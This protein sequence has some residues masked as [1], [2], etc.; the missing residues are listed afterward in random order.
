[1][2]SATDSMM[3]IGRQTATGRVAR[4][5]LAAAI[6]LVLVGCVSS[7]DLFEA[8]GT[9][10][11]SGSLMN[12]GDTM[13]AAGDH[14]GAV[15]LYRSAHDQQPDQADPLIRMGRAL[16]AAG[17]YAD[18]AEAFRAAL[19]R[20]PASAEAKRGLGNALVGLGQ[21]ALAV[22]YLRDAVQATEASD[23]MPDWRACL[24]LG[25]ALDL[26][27]DPVAA[28]ESYRR[29]L[30]SAPDNPD[31][32]N[33]LGLSLALSGSADQALPMLEALVARHGTQ[34]RY[35]G[36]LAIAYAL[37]GRM[38]D[39]ARLMSRQSPPDMV[40]RNLTSLTAIRAMDDHARKALAIRMV[41]TG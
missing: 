8:R 5:L 6:S 30:E 31:L 15:A 16:A 37:D 25:V 27:G 10:P 13:M 7:N 28:Q 21:P 34:G 2:E 40:A 3:T 17:A 39:A 9:P 36:T 29:G 18:A 38:E 14:S 22:G 11:V 33:N 32:V 24:G 35:L 41:Y 1:M 26:S 20:D 23:G 12:A 4:H 19:D